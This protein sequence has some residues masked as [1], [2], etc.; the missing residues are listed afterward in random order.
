[1]ASIGVFE[2][3]NRLSELVERAARGE[4][5]TITRRGEIVARLVPPAA[6]AA[7]NQAV[8]AIEALRQ[9]RLA[10]RLD[11]ESLKALRETGRR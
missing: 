9:A 11:G 8:A 5:I 1:M 3:K 4:E 7:G 6:V 10:A 2:A